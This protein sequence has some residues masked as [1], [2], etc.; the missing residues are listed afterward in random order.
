MT[1][2]KPGHTSLNMSDI[3]ED[4]QVEFHHVVKLNPEFRENKS[5]DKPVDIKYRP[6][7]IKADDVDL[8]AG[9]NANNIAIAADP[10]DRSTVLNSKMLNGH[11]EDYF[12]TA[13]NGS[14]VANKADTI[15]KEFGYDITD[16]RNEVY[17]IK[18][19]L[20][21]QGLITNTYQRMGYN[22]I[23]R[24]GYKPYEYEEVGRPIADCKDYMTIYLSSSDTEKLDDF[25]YIAIYFIDTKAVDIIQIAS[26][27][28]DKE[29]ITLDESM[30]TSQNISADNLIIYKTA[31]I[32]RDGNFYFAKDADIVPSDISMYT[33]FDDDTAASSLLL[34]NKEGLGYSNTFRIPEKKL[35]LIHI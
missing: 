29:T 14:S 24:N 21:K 18:H 32:S 10:S 6:N 7:M 30:D 35:S 16:L 4:L 11:T 15:V 28:A 1:M 31:G 25:D 27:G 5:M 20:E 2:I 13:Q 23:F 19:A 26:I 22:D 9:V 3:S 17:E 8:V 33:G 34:I 12:M